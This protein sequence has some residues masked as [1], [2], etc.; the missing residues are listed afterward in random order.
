MWEGEGAGDLW[1]RTKEDDAQAVA[2]EAAGGEGEDIQNP[3]AGGVQ[4][5]GQGE[6]HPGH[7]EQ[8][9]PE[10][11]TQRHINQANV[12]RSNCLM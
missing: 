6:S 3:V 5:T 2:D 9:R 11:C 7:P 4:P 12:M 10:T 8:V 1:R